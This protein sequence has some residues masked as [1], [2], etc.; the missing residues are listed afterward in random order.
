MSILTPF[1]PNSRKLLCKLVRFHDSLVTSYSNLSS[2]LVPSPCLPEVDFELQTSRGGYS[3]GVGR[4]CLTLGS[5]YPTSVFTTMHFHWSW[6]LARCWHTRPPVTCALLSVSA[7]VPLWDVGRK[8]LAVSLCAG[9]VLP[10]LVYIMQTKIFFPKV[11]LEALKPEVR[12]ALGT[13]PWPSL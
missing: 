10:V 9:L 8:I 12:G 7:Q 3:I 6:P 4:E 11:S 1:A 5:S 13:A 2:R